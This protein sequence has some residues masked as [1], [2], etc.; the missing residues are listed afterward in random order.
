MSKT[1][2]G[3]VTVREL[4]DLLDKKGD[5]TNRAIEEIAHEVSGVKENVANI[6]GRMMYIPII[7]SVSITFFGIIVSILIRK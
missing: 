2:G 7:I 4:Y 3:A 5:E 1:N 6:Q